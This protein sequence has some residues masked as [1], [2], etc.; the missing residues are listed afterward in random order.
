MPV[1]LFSAT[2]DYLMGKI[3]TV[4]IPRISIVDIR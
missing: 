2:E 3:M 4:N 1:L